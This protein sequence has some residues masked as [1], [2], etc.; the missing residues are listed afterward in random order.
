[1]FRVFVSF[2]ISLPP[3]QDANFLAG[4]KALDELERRDRIHID[5]YCVDKAGKVLD[6]F[7]DESVPEAF[8]TFF[9]DLRCVDRNWDWE[10]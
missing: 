4:L 2:Y 7:A 1:M 3:E 8:W 9:H 6:P 5:V 10:G